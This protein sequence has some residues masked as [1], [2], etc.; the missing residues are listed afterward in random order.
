MFQYD[1]DMLYVRIP[2][3]KWAKFVALHDILLEAIKLKKDWMN[4]S[5]YRT[6]ND[7]LGCERYHQLAEKIVIGYQELLV[8][9]RLSSV[10]LDENMRF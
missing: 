7:L 9:A 8:T 2:V 4:Q 3:S 1:S 6:D 5:D 10:S